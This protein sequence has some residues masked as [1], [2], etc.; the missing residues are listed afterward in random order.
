MPAA[1]LAI[2]FAVA[3]AIDDD[4]GRV[5]QPDVPDLRLLREAE[6]VGRDGLAGE[7]LQRERRDELL[8]AA[9]S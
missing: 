1:S 4:V 9:P 7:R 3:G 2:T 8:R 6:G 5:G